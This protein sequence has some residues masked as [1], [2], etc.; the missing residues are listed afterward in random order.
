MY[1]DVKECLNSCVVE[2][3]AG[4]EARVPVRRPIKLLQ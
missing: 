1:L 4:G 2:P 3:R